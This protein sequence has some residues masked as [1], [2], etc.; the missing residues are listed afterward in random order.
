MS[1]E[2]PGVCANIQFI[3][4]AVKAWAE[5]LAR[6]PG[7][8]MDAELFDGDDEPQMLSITVAVG[9]LRNVATPPNERSRAIIHACL[10]SPLISDKALDDLREAL[11]GPVAKEKAEEGVR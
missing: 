2:T 4:D 11:I 9:G 5:E 1:N 3:S 8:L 6:D 10:E 7:K